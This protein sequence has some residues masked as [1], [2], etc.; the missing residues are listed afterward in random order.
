[1][2]I[3]RSLILIRLHLSRTINEIHDSSVIMVALHF[4]PG[5]THWMEI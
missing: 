2:L 3:N 1:L 4:R 5:L